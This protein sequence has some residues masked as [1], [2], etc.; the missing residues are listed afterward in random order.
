MKVRALTL[1]WAWTTLGALA[2]FALLAWMDLRLKA[3]TGYG[4]VDLQKTSSAQDINVI[5]DRWLT[6]D[7]A[8]A[9]G[10]SLGFDYLFMPLYG[11]AF[12]FSGLIARDWIAAKSG[13]LRRALT[14]VSAVPL[15]GAICDAVENALES[16]MLI[17]GASDRMAQLAFMAT[18]A[19]SICFFTG[20]ALFVLALLSF[21]VRRRKPASA[22]A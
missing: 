12:Y 17:S 11:F 18:N 1:R 13:L 9:A 19:K 20:L 10:F 2:C 16:T 6:R 14:L 15:A 3:Q 5:I 4:T 21:L 22:G 8:A 7:H